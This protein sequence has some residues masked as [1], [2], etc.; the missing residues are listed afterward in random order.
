MVDKKMHEIIRIKK[1]SIK[2]ARL[3]ISVQ[4]EQ[5]VGGN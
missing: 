5:Q 1:V 2:N 4:V 3:E